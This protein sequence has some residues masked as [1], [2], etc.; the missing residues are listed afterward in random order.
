MSRLR[1]LGVDWK[2]VNCEHIKCEQ[3]NALSPMKYS[4][5]TFLLSVAAELKCIKYSVACTRFIHNPPLT[6]SLP[7]LCAKPI[8]WICGYRDGEN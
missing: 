3:S 8:R 6:E 4:M 1:E 2:P 5:E 7:R